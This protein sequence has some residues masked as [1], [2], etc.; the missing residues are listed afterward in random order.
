M[1]NDL[2]SYAKYQVFLNYPFDQ[3]FEP[4]ANAIHFSVI[5]AG[6]IP[7][8]ARDLTVPDR[9]RLEMLTDAITKCRYSIHDFSQ[10]KGQGNSNFARFNMPLEMGM[11]LFHALTTQRTEHRCAFF[12]AT[13]YDYQRFASDL[14]GL[15]P[16]PYDN[17]ELTLVTCVYEWLRGLENPLTVKLA[18]VKVKNKYKH[19]KE[20][21]GKIEGSGKDDHPSHDEAQELMIQMCS[22]CKWWQW[23]DGIPGQLEFSSVPLSR[24][25]MSGT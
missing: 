7:V 25:S 19:F 1:R 13:P 20:E 8:C 18:T 17:D 9:P 11:A 2:A 23:R 14:A 5:A 12:V 10:G 16:K 15:D 3:E 21:L 6:L 22:E 4:L 24:K